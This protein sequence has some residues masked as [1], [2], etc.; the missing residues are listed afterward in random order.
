[1]WNA[2]HHTHM[3]TH[4]VCTQGPHYSNPLRERSEG[5]NWKPYSCDTVGISWIHISLRFTLLTPLW[6]RC[7]TFFF[8]E[9]SENSEPSVK[10]PRIIQPLVAGKNIYITWTALCLINTA[11][12]FQRVVIMHQIH[13]EISWGLNI[14]LIPEG[15]LTNGLEDWEL[16][17]N[18]QIIP[19]A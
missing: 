11:S 14:I 12:G 15:G 7:Y 9:T 6:G 10:F 17:Y 3:N 19:N 5:E 2:S 8:V 18:L 13:L 1:M 16:L 4:H